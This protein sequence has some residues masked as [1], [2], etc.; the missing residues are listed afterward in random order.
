MDSTETDQES[1]GWTVQRQVTK[2]QVGVGQYRD[3]SLR[4]RLELDGID[5]SPRRKPA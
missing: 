1:G 3:G 5:R 2:G 4:S